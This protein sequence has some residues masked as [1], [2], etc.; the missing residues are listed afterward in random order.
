MSSRPPCSPLTMAHS[1]APC[2][3]SHQNGL[4][5][6]SRSLAAVLR[7]VSG[8][9]RG[10]ASC[11]TTPLRRHAGCLLASAAASHSHGLTASEAAKFAPSASTWTSGAK[12]D[13]T[14]DGTQGVSTP[15]A[16]GSQARPFW[17]GVCPKLC[18]TQC[19]PGGQRAT[20]ARVASVRYAVFLT[21][22]DC[23]FLTNEQATTIWWYNQQHCSFVPA[24]FVS[25]G[26]L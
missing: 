20:N 16:H 17:S 8:S 11:W 15:S 24:H 25:S 7:S 2:T 10:P 5:T 14:S 19:K 12:A 4:P 3:S 21:R 26:D 9:W 1:P 18:A 6:L 22:S 23:E 13:G